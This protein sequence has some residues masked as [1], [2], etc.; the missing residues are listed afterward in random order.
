MNTPQI[1]SPFSSILN[2]DPRSNPSSENK[3]EIQTDKNTIDASASNEVVFL[4]LYP[5][6]WDDFD[7]SQ[8]RGHCGYGRIG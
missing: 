4:V 5:H 3:T 1:L 7:D 2:D 6:P 8:W